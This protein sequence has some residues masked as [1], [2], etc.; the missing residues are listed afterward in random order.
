MTALERVDLG[1]QELSP[2]LHFDD[3]A[4][5]QALRPET[6]FAFDFM[7]FGREFSTTDREMD[8]DHVPMSDGGARRPGGNFLYA[9]AC[10]SGYGLLRRV[11]RG[12]G[13]HPG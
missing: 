11:R 3:I 5:F 1:S 2:E 12:N 10:I 7:L 8:L 4:A 6:V 13:R 9:G